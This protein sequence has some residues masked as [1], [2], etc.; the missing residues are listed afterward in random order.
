[1]KV[2]V[3]D[4]FDDSNQNTITNGTGASTDTSISQAGSAF[5]YVK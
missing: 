3:A 1:V 4:I 5:I 2:A